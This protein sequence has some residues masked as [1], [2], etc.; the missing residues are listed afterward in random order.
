MKA[1]RI[2]ARPRGF[3]YARLRPSKARR[4]MTN[5][6]RLV[7][8][9]IGTPEPVACIEYEESGCLR[10][11][12]YVCRYWP[13]GLDLTALLYR[14]V[15][16]GPEV[17]PLLDEL[18]RFTLRQ[19]D[20]GV[21]HLDYNPGNILARK[22][23]GG[24]EF[25][26]IDLNRLRFKRVDI[27]DRISGLVRLTS[28]LDYLRLIGRRYAERYGADP[29]DFC[30]RLEAAHARHMRRRRTVKAFKSSLRRET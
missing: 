27:D 5:A 14:G 6:E 28:V 2:P 11:S 26:L 12:Y 30:R 23:E 3:V 16:G 24:F 15:S 22:G 19:H 29:I 1:F 18:A 9:G 8:L 13:P 25:A 10:D 7:A 20:K 21:L 17:A 4:S